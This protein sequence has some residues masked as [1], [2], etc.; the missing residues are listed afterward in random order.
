MEKDEE[1][2][3]ILKF[4]PRSHTQTLA[5]NLKIDYS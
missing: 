2:W 4:W 3:V 5:V 1:D